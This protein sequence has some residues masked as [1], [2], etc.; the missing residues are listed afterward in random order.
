[1]R[2]MKERMGWVDRLNS[3]PVGKVDW[4]LL[5]V[6]CIFIVSTMMYEDMI[7]IYNHSLTFLDSFFDMDMANFYANTLAKP[8][9]GFGAVYYWIVYAVIG[10]WNLPIWILH[11]FVEFD[12]FSALCLLWAKM[13]MILFLFLTLWVME[14]ILK[15]FGFGKEKYRFVQFM[16][17]SSLLVVMPVVAIAQIDIITVFLM[18]WG[19]WEYLR[20]DKISWKFL[21]I[22]SFAAALKIFALFIFIPL[23]LLKEKR[24]LYVLR[25][26]LVGM[27]GIAVCLLPYAGKADY[28][29]ATSVLND[30]MIERMF[31]TAFP[32]GNTILPAFM[33]IFV[34]VC[35]WAYALE[36]KTGEEYFYYT[37]WISLAVFAGFFCFMYSHPYWIVLMAPFVA[38]LLVF[39]ADKMK[40]NLI[41]EFFMSAGISVFYAGQFDVYMSAETFKDMLLPL[42]GLPPTTNSITGGFWKALERYDLE[43]YT[44]ILYVIFVACLGALLIFNRPDKYAKTWKDKVS[45]K[46]TFDHGMIYLRLFSIFAFI[47]GCI[48]FSYISYSS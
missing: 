39:N 20:E 44:I 22:F 38:I 24:I 25:D 12:V 10:I 5:A 15:E 3:L 40:L 14:K 31:Q 17:A 4:I 48:Y 37:N 41:L 30:S 27:I 21:A 34:S 18:L 19:I 7:I 33:L 8:Y 43:L 6:M 45:E 2:K 26:W 9:E 1:M 29:E 13:E 35:I 11:K 42:V 16:F 47:L 36:L 46:L 23:V 32:G 28:I